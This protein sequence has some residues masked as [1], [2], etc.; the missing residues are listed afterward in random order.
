MAIITARTHVRQSGTGLD[1]DY[2]IA[3]T[4]TGD[5][6]ANGYDLYVYARVGGRRWAR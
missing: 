6:L 4:M 1:P 2:G 3:V 5:D